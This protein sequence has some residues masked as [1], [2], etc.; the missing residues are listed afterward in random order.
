[1][2]K[3]PSDHHRIVSPTLHIPSDT[4]Q[5][6]LLSCQ[7]NLSSEP[8]LTCI[9]R[10]GRNRLSLTSWGRADGLDRRFFLH[11]CQKS[12]IIESHVRISTDILGIAYRD[13]LL[14]LLLVGHPFVHHPLALP[15]DFGVRSELASGRLAYT[16]LRPRLR[17]RICGPWRGKL[18]PLAREYSIISKITEKFRTF[19]I[20]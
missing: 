12:P 14:L 4:S 3:K 9:S 10:P 8:P 11:L 18:L 20:F 17:K 5:F 19:C 2:T 13:R 7:R 1:M 15:P 6:G 16:S